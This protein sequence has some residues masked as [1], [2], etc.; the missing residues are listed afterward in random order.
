MTDDPTAPPVWQAR[1]SH[2]RIR[3]WPGEASAV[4]F[5]AEAGEALLLR[6][7]HGQV[8]AELAPGEPVGEPVLRA[9]FEGLDVCRILYELEEAGFVRRLAENR[10]AR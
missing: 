1:L 2:L 5:D 4:A 3:Q 10:S 6:A 9:R 7:G 8:L